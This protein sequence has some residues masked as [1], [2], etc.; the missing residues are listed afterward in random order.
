MPILPVLALYKMFKYRKSPQVRYGLSR[1]LTVIKMAQILC[2]S[3]ESVGW[4]VINWG[5]SHVGCAS[6]AHPPT[7]IHPSAS[8][9]ATQ[10]FCF[11]GLPPLDGVPTPPPPKQ[12]CRGISSK[13]CGVAMICASYSL[14][15]L[16]SGIW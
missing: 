5:P 12:G 9:P 13:L 2:I 6:Q 3:D 15:Q 7:P 10:T 11:V 14:L 16:N 4:F 8:V 1:F